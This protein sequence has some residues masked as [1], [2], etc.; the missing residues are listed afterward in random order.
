MQRYA[1]L[2]SILLGLLLFANLLILRAHPAA[3]K[4]SWVSVRSGH[5][6]L[7]G[8]ASEREIRKV[9]I[10]LEQFRAAFSRLFGKANL[11]SSVPTTVI[12]FKNLDSYRPF[13]PTYQGKTVEVAG[14]FQPGE[15]VNYITL[16][17]EPR[18]TDPYRT[19]FHEYVHSLTNDNTNIAPPW[20]SEGL[21][22]FYSTLEVSEGDKK[23]TLGKPIANHL[24]LLRE[25][26]FLPLHILFTVDHGSPYYNER[27][28]K[29]VFY[30]Q[31]WALMHY[32]ILGNKGQRWPQ[33]G[34]YLKLLSSGKPIEESFQQAFQTDPATMEKELRDY[35]NRYTYTV[36]QFTFSERL[37]F[38]PQIQSAPVSEAETQYY[39]GDLLL[40]LNRVDAEEYLQRALRL[41]PN[42]AAAHA[43]LGIAR[44][45]KQRFEEAK[46][47]LERAVA[48]DSRNY[49]A[50]YYYAFALSRGNASGDTITGFPEGAVPLMRSHLK[51]AIE[52]APNFP[53]SYHLLA[54][55]NLI[56]GQQLDESIELLKR[57]LTL[58]PGKH[59]LILMLAQIY[60]RKQELETARQLVE[61][62]ARNSADPQ[63]RAQ[64]QSL[65]ETIRHMAEQMAHFRTE[66][67]SV[68][69]ETATADRAEKRAV[70]EAGRP[71]LRRRFEGE[72]VCGLLMR[73]ECL[74]DGLRLVIKVG[75]RTLTLHSTTPEKIQFLTYSQEGGEVTNCGPRDPGVP[76][77][78]TYRTSTD[79]RSKFDGEPVV[80]E[81]IRPE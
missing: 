2:L 76:V 79:A 28:K 19:I 4:D 44:M 25:K 51:K 10:K 42:L 77:L 75:D 14:Y 30:A 43:S 26:K 40:H 81:F 38:N 36:T 74:E 7:V 71:T 47:H 53:E 27:D 54:F 13:M 50:H 39:L 41:D 24:F 18:G 78:V 1:Q 68:T 55:I 64:A 80:V 48:A 35:I 33:L 46:Q 62:I 9:A 57:A 32:L 20:F 21:A 65:L 37:E 70:I 45:R 16:T 3:A 6:F 15:D 52:L 34:Q 12:V 22:E 63:M 5:F 31:S 56:T 8:N 49:L 66:R 11:N 67:S 60:L 29:G 61:P 73:I 58:A 23:V 72:K 59:E 69:G 17:A